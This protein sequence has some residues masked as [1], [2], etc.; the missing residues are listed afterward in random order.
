MG[1]PLMASWTITIFAPLCV[2][3]RDQV[4]ECGAPCAIDWSLEES[5]TM[6]VGA[7]WDLQVLH[8]LRASPSKT[9]QC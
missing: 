7:P 5:V 1:A 3:P 2:E 9:F 4:Q 8:P 6:A